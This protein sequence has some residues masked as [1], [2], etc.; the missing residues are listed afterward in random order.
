MIKPVSLACG[1]S[2]CMKCLHSIISLANNAT[3]TTAPCPVC[4]T[5]FHR[6]RLL[7]NVNLDVLTK[8][9][10][11]HC[12]NSGCQW[13]GTLEHAREHDKSCPKAVVNC[14]NAGCDHSAVR[15]EIEGHCNNCEKAMINCSGCQ[16]DVRRGRLPQHKRTECYFSQIDCP[17]GCDAKFPR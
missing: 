11:M 4:R 3:T 2:G 15:E 7:L 14:P 13:E 9:L 17:L 16:K 10:G 12:S 6:D 1:H 8:N 5:N